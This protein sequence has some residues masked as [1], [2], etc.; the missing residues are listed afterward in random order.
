ME[1]STPASQELV[2]VTG[3]SGF[4]ASW[5]I[6]EL[7]SRGYR[8]RT[9]VRSEAREAQ[10]RASIAGR[11]E[12]GDRLSFVRANLLED[13]G[14]AEAVEG[15]AY[16]IHPAS[17]MPVGEYAGTDL[18]TP[19]REGARRV[20]EAARRSGAKRVV[21]TSS[22]EA[23]KP[24]RPD[25]T[26]TADTWTDLEGAAVSDYVRA[27]TLAERDVWAWAAANSGTEVT[28]I[29]PGFIQGP[30]LGADYSGSVELI[31]MLLSGKLRMAPRLGFCMIDV[32][33]LADLHVRA[34]LSPAAAG[35]RFVATSD[36]LW[37][38]EVARILR[39]AFP[40]RAGR[41]PSGTAPDLVIKAAALV[42]PPMREMLPNLGKR[43]D[44][45][46]TPALQLL[47]WKPRPSREAMI[48]GAASLIGRG[49][50]A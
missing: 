7:L 14:W 19:A 9:T 29:L 42:S 39:E 48:D 23:C 4:L 41:L 17:P 47:G 20:L 1:T 44:F 30:V 12:A 18:I 36:F 5:I 10:A 40:E 21:V 38:E 28:T 37:V 31:A 8:V 33:D 22:V 49:L 16:V 26:G 32:R 15:A 27:K 50:V 11:V 35:R 13:E 25:A 34:M 6:V 43:T 2:A 24:G 3:G 45:D 46:T